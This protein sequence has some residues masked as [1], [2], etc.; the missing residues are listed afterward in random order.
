MSTKEDY[1]KNKVKMQK[2]NA[3]LDSQ[4]NK[5]KTRLKKLGVS[6]KMKDSDLEKL[7]RNFT[8]TIF[9]F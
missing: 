2:L 7:L 3:E 5:V 8:T 9:I 4:V 6:S 1:K